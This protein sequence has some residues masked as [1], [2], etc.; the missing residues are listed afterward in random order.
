MNPLTEIRDLVYQSRFTESFR[1]ILSCREV[2]LPYIRTHSWKLKP[3]RKTLWLDDGYGL[4]DEGWGWGSGNGYGN[5][6]GNG[7]GYG[8]NTGNGWGYDYGDGLG[9]G[10]GWGDG[11]GWGLGYGSG[12]G[13]SGGSGRPWKR[14]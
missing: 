13:W 6:L 7:W 3:I 1:L 5:S 10:S 4:G 2:G 8:F 11:S 9:Y 12:D 14:I